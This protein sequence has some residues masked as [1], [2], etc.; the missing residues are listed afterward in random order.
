MATG[1]ATEDLVP[2]HTKL[3]PTE[4]SVAAVA[5]VALLGAALVALLGA[6]LV[7]L[8]CAIARCEN[9][10]PPAVKEVKSIAETAIADSVV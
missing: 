1:S 2:C 8:V 10:I 7:A 4:G 9:S 5:A 3:W 6:A